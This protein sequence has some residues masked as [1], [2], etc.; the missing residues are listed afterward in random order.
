MRKVLKIGLPLLL[1]LL[2]IYSIVYIHTVRQ[3]EGTLLC[4]YEQEGQIRAELVSFPSLHKK[5]LHA[6]GYHSIWNVALRNDEEFYCYGE[7]E[8]GGKKML[9]R[10]ALDGTVLSEMPAAKYYDFQLWDSDHLAVASG[11]SSILLL[12]PATGQTKLLAE[13]TAE[14]AF[15][16]NYPSFF[17]KDNALV[18]ARD[19]DE[20][21]RRENDEAD[22]GWYLL[23]NGQ[24]RQLA[25]LPHTDW[26]GGF[27]A[28]RTLLFYSDTTAEAYRLSVDT[29]A[30]TPAFAVRKHGSMEK[31]T[32][33][34]QLPEDTYCIGYNLSSNVISSALSLSTRR[35]YNMETGRSLAA[36]PL[37]VCMMGKNWNGPGTRISPVPNDMDN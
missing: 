1:V 32:E 24:E 27:V 31:G 28:D 11:E 20:A 21:Q 3:I 33:F 16:R 34:Y 22:T 10:V 13:N 23:E 8:Q 14:Q 26:C 9:L 7:Q 30:Q 2:C 19:T 5:V 36:T 15:L 18:F 25:V 12:E 4:E 35:I 6:E 29:L 17:C 37:L